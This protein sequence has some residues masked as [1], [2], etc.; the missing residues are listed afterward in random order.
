MVNF[1][2]CGTVAQIYESVKSARAKNYAN[3]KNTGGKMNI[4]AQNEPLKQR[5][6]AK[7]HGDKIY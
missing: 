5:L 3:V 7:K 4:K 6:S 2:A 1:A